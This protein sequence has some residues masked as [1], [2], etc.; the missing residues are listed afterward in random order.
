MHVLE[1]KD[2]SSTSGVTQMVESR[3]KNVRFRTGEYFSLGGKSWR[4]IIVSIKG[5]NRMVRGTG[6]K[7]VEVWM[8]M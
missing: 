5:M 1:I 7:T 2:F 6:C 4:E 8:S 3:H